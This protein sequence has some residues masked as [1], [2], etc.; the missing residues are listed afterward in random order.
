MESLWRKKEGLVE[1]AI[2]FTFEI[3]HWNI[4]YLVQPLLGL[5]GAK[6]G[7]VIIQISCTILG[8]RLL[9]IKSKALQWPYGYFRL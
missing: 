7:Q 6:V 4:W 3:I 9:S 5:P 1:I 2:S 8:E